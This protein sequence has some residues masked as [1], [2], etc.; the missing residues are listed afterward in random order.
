MFYNYD[1]DEKLIKLANESEQAIQ[2]QFKEID[3]IALTNSAKVLKAFHDERVGTN[4]FTE[5]TGYGFS[6]DGRD[7]LERIYAR[8]FK[9]EDALVRP[10]IMSGTHALSLTFFGLLKHGDTF[11]SISGAPYDSLLS[12]IGIEGN[13]RNSLAKHGIKYEQIDLINN[14]FDIDSI[15]KRLSKQDVKLVE[16]Q[17]SK[18]YSQRESL[19]IDKIERVCRAIREV[20]KDVIIMQGRIHFYEGC[21]RSFFLYMPN[22]LLWEIWVWCRS[23]DSG[24][25]KS[26]LRITVRKKYKK[27]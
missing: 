3:R 25:S 22:Q 27:Q 10:Q 17:R 5:I 8:I 1:I 4:D 21:G 19:S 24:K 9:A 7:K 20:N 16:I 23:W 14:D 18:G 12:I 26:A 6:D 2:E 13:S 11:I 15:K